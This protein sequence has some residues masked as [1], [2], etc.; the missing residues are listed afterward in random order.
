MD[1]LDLFEEIFRDNK[2]YICLAYRKDMN[3]ETKLEQSFFHWADDTEQ[4]KAWIEEHKSG[5]CYFCPH[6]L[7]EPIRRKKYA[8]PGHTL[9]ADLDECSYDKLGKYV[10]PTPKYVVQ[11]SPNHQQAYWILADD[12][13]PEEYEA[14]TRRIALAYKDEGC[15]QSG[16]DLTQLLRIPS[17]MNNKGEPFKVTLDQHPVTIEGYNLTVLGTEI[18]DFIDLPLLPSLSTPHRGERISRDA[19]PVEIKDLRIPDSV[20]EYLT[21]PPPKGERSEAAWA[22]ILAMKEVGYSPKQIYATIW[23]N[24]LSK[25]YTAY[26][27]E[28]DVGRAFSKAEEMPMPNKFKAFAGDLEQ[29][30]EAFPKGETPF[31]IEG[32]LAA[33]GQSKALISGSSGEGKTTLAEVALV[34]A[35]RGDPIFGKRRVPF[36]LRMAL[37]DFEAT[38]DSIADDIELMIPVLGKPIMENVLI[39]TPTGEP[40]DSLNPASIDWIWAQLERFRPHITWMDSVYGFVSQ[41]IN[42]EDRALAVRRFAERIISE[43]HSG[44]V[45]SHH[46]KA[47]GEFAPKG[48]F[49]QT[50]GVLGK[51]LDQWAATKLTYK[52]LPE[53]QGFGILEGS[54]RIA[55]WNPVKLVLQ[56]HSPSK[57]I[58]EI[59][60]DQ[61]ALS[62]EDKKKLLGEDPEI[63]EVK[64]ILLELL[65]RGMTNNEVADRLGVNKS[66]VSHWR[67]GDWGA[68]EENVR[69]L[70]QLA[71]EVAPWRK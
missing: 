54:T 45:I 49:E 67:A 31:L 44:V 41:L 57:T 43:A 30:K 51:R 32:L 6:L 55:A 14:L 12:M 19:P 2:G 40:F 47:V 53:L 68:T 28:Q 4:I 35:S 25:R 52:F 23:A 18:S 5:N 60:P 56:Y 61:I 22:V 71:E 29:L 58:W 62:H 34:Q 69:K 37:I 9:W 7:S 16:W 66:T 59:D 17:T 21:F 63:T 64:Q 50:M 10:E 3:P 1:Y 33:G 26:Q 27:L 13:E 39:L 24:P 46:I 70:K 42:D 65:M 38:Q 11:T 8:L 20:K 36:S 15:D 48:H